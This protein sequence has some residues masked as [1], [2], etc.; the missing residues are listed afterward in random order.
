MIQIVIEVAG[1][2]RLN[3]NKGKRNVLLFN[4]DGI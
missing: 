2:C 3:I 4:H 1:E